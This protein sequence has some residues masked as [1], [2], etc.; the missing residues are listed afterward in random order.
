M[1]RLTPAAGAPRDLRE[2]IMIRSAQVGPDAVEGGRGGQE[3]FAR[4]LL[5]KLGLEG[6]ILACQQ[7]CWD[8]ILKIILERKD[9]LGPE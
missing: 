9:D 5:A 8:G 7:N 2:R 4:S 6:A 3:K 1:T